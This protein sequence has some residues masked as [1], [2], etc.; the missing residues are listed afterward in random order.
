MRDN[1]ILGRKLCN[2]FV[3]GVNAVQTTYNN[4]SNSYL[5]VITNKEKFVSGL[6][7]AYKTKNTNYFNGV[8][9]VN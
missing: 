6:V 2:I 8:V 1:G 9:G 4:F 5:L 7:T 3:F